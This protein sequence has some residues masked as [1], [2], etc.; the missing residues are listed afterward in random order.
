[1]FE[2]SL[3]YRASSGTAKATWRRPVSNKQTN[4]KRKKKEKRRKR[5]ERTGKGREGKSE[6]NRENEQGT[7]WQISW[8]SA[9]SVAPGQFSYQNQV[10]NLG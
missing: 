8:Y 4:T 9:P 2:P 3:V 10:S 7:S 5:Q 6:K 1:M